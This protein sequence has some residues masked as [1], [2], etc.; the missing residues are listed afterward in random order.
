MN[1]LGLETRMQINL[2][3]SNLSLPHSSIIQTLALILRR[4]PSRIYHLQVWQRMTI[5]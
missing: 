1:S 3:P 2:R 5:T 4:A